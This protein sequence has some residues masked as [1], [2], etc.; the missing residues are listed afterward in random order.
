MK[1]RLN[2]I[3]LAA[4]L[5][6]CAL[7]GMAFAE[8]AA[9]ESMEA[10]TE[11]LEVATEAA[12]AAGEETQTAE[13][14]TA[15]TEAS[16]SYTVLTENGKYS[17]YYD[18]MVTSAENL[19][20]QLSVMPVETLDEYIEGSDEAVMIMCATWESY[21]DELGT[22][23][24]VNGEITIEEDGTDVNVTMNDVAYT[25]LASNATTN[26]TCTFDMKN[27]TQALDWE[28]N[29]PMSK[30]IAEAGL[31]TLLGLGTVFVV[32][33]FLAFVIGNIHWIPDFI[34][35]RQK[36]KAAA[37]APAEAPAPVAAPIV[38][39]EELVD[40]TE[41]V[42]VIAAAIAAAEQTTTDGFVVRSIK[43]ANRR[44]WLNA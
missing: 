10:A 11:A 3:L 36:K 15:E 17:A 13:T 26:V 32:L 37:N 25:E 31:N 18:Q 29:Y 23:T 19:I 33:L 44:N 5:S 41:L 7:S 6:V 2:A 22:C 8:E 28:I 40:D 1:N 24:G 39:E 4:G 43:K 27:N 42:A 12:A 30:L 20:Q 21:M 35:G 34:E 38:E 14:Q 9:T 16:V